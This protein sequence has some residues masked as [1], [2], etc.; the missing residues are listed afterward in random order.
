MHKRPD[1]I[2]RVREMWSPDDIESL[3]LN[4]GNFAW[5]VNSTQKNSELDIN[6]PGISHTNEYITNQIGEI[7]IGTVFNTLYFDGF[8]EETSL[9][10]IGK[11]AI[12]DWIWENVVCKQI[13][14]ASLCNFLNKKRKKVKPETFDLIVV[15][16]IDYCNKCALLL[17]KKIGEV[18]SEDLNNS[19]IVDLFI[20]EFNQ[21]KS[22]VKQC[23]LKQIFK[24]TSFHRVELKISKRKR[25]E[26][27]HPLVLRYLKYCKDQGTL[28]SSLSNLSSQLK[29]VLIW[30]TSVP[31]DLNCYSMN[32][33][34]V[35]EINHSHLK[36]YR[37]Y[38]QRMV[39]EETYTLRGASQHMVYVTSFFQYLY[40]TEV[41]SSDI[42]RGIS[43]IVSDPYEYRDIPKDEEIK[44]LIK[45]VMLYSDNPVVESLCY[46]L[47]LNMGLRNV[48]VANLQWQ[49]INLETNILTID[50]HQ[51]PI[52]TSIT[53]LFGKISIAK[54]GLVF[55]QE[56]SKYKGQIYNN[57][58]LYKQIAGW[59]YEG[60]VHLLRHTFIT[61]MA[62]FLPP[63]VLKEVARHESDR[64]TALYV[65]INESKLRDAV[66]TLKFL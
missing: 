31:L 8:A 53:R 45:T 13:K 38:L 33:I 34:P 62:E 10:P 35:W 57:F 41:I 43:K 3:E 6:F 65:H 4:F 54:K 30:L 7:D 21:Q 24:A 58:K 15:L 61:R 46:L 1:E 48:E 36:G 16:A 14:S 56:P 5:N 66:N 51:L 50:Q 47:M 52:P 22:S 2:F 60:G 32:D 55:T 26:F 59:R 20:H 25:E 39:A 63:M 23:Y 44:A 27:I 42:T 37:K 29:R 11:K 17:E 49:D 28:D 9:K 12:N 18:T 40:E 19:R 64:T